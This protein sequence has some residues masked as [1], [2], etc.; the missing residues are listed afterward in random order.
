M[1]KLTID[2]GEE[3]E[4]PGEGATAGALAERGA[5]TDD[6]IEVQAEEADV[7]SRGS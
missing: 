4:A 3:F 6:W 5:V 2:E 7:N 1:K